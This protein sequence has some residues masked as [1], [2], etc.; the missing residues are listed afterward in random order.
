MW[1]LTIPGDHDFYIQTAATATTAAAAVLVHNQN[2]ETC[3]VAAMVAANRGSGNAYS[4]A[5]RTELPEDF[6]PGVSR[7]AHFQAAN[8]QLLQAMNEDP[9]FSSMMEEL[10]PGIKDRLVGPT[11]GIVRDFA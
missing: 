6:Y 7:R 10:T 3:D 2:G 1:D 8:R 5:F 9:E 4:V 11:R